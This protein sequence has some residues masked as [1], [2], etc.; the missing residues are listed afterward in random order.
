MSIDIRRTAH[1]MNAS[2]QVADTAVLVQLII[3]AQDIGRGVPV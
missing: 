1:S 3:A 2:V